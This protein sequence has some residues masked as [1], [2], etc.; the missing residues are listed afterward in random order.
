MENMMAAQIHQYGGPEVLALESV[1]RRRPGPGEVLI[2][3]HAA[4]V[5][6]VDWKI[7]AGYLKEFMPLS[8]PAILGADFAGEVEAV[9]VG[10]T[11]LREGGGAYGIA[12]AAYAE[13]V[14]AQEDRIA[15]KPRCVDFF[16]AAGIPLAAL[17]AW[18]ALFDAGELMEGQS[19][20]VHGAAGGVGGFAVQLAKINGAYVIGTGSKRNESF[21]R[22]LGADRV[23]D[24]RTTRFENE[25]RDLDL[26]L[27]TQGGETQERSW[28]VLREGGTLVSIVE[29]PS[30]AEAA[31]RL[32]KAKLVTHLPNARD[33][34]E[35]TRLVEKWAA[36]GV[37]GSVVIA[38]RGE[39]RSRDKSIGTYARKI[40]LQVV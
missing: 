4:G 14:V 5:N 23:I 9:G 12:K 39:A 38:C 17:T 29:P 24:Y 28:N 8:M 15:L 10:V 31:K 21:L 11:H 32:L 13:F 30:Q 25:V 37:C 7:R 26:V 16:Q 34:E 33:P 22:E 19:V 27:D 18:Q 2:R 20:L 40:V 6:P 35:I 3:V 36:E 1:P